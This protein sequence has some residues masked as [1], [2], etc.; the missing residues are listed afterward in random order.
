MKAHRVQ[1]FFI[2][3]KL[4]SCS[5]VI[6]FEQVLA[7]RRS[8][9]GEDHSKGALLIKPNCRVGFVLGHNLFDDLFQYFVDVNIYP[10][11]YFDIL[12]FLYSY[13][14]LRPHF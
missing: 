9:D 4:H 6:H 10:C 7:S 11:K 13:I 5:F 12:A 1:C 2:Y 14:L 8:Y 3:F